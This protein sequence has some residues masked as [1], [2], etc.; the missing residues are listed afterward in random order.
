VQ[1][2]IAAGEAADFE[3]SRGDTALLNAAR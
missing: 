2:L 3:T 1:T